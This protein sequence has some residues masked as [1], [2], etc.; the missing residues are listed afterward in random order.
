MTRPCEFLLLQYADE[1]KLYVPVSSLHLINR[2]TGVADEH[3]TAASASAATAWQRE[4]EKAATTNS[5][6][7][8]RIAGNL[9]AP[10][11]PPR[12]CPASC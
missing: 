5:R 4:R 2:Y 9:R 1:A 8:R 6:C 12:H 10:R 11:C 3:G 7:S